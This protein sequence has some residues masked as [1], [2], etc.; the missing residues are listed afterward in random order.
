MTLKVS[1]E[2]T[3]REV[4]DGQKDITYDDKTYNVSIKVEDVILCFRLLSKSDD[5]IFTNIFT[6]TKIR[7]R[8][9]LLRQVMIMRWLLGCFWP[10]RQ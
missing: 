10:W 4:N 6:G 2:Y 3:V 9:I 5:M 1:F 8:R 7:E